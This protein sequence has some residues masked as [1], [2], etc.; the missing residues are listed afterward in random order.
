MIDLLVFI[1]CCVGLITVIVLLAL[2][3]ILCIINLLV[4]IRVEIQN[5]KGS[6][7]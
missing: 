4:A 1:L 5:W 2:F 7:E 3:L 6:D